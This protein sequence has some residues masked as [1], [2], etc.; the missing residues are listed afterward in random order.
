MYAFRLQVFHL[1]PVMHNVDWLVKAA[2]EYVKEGKTIAKG[3][4]P[5]MS[6]YENLLQLSAEVP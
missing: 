4:K 6:R 5:F 1:L 3:M 2:L